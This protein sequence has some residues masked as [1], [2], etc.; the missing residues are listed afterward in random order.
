M[1]PAT[2]AI[3]LQFLKLV[4]SLLE[5]V[6]QVRDTLKGDQAE[7]DAI[8]AEISAKANAVADELRAMPD[9]PV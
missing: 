4:P 3:I 6:P 2:A 5:L 1:N 7:V 8:H 9:D